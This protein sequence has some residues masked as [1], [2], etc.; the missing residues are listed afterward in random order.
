MLQH[1]DLGAATYEIAIIGHAGTT[2][3]NRGDSGA[4]VFVHEDGKYKAAGLLIG[5]V[6]E[7]NI[8]FATPLR[9]VLET[10]GGYEWA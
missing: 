2:F 6:Q 10:S 9:L 4:C 8:T 7:S 1:W 3:A 5:K